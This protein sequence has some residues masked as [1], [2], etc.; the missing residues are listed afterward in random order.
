MPSSTQLC[1]SRLAVLLPASCVIALGALAGACGASAE[2][3]GSLTQ[4]P[5]DTGVPVAPSPQE[6]TNGAGPTPPAP[7]PPPAAPTPAPPTDRPT[8]LS[9]IPADA[10]KG[11]KSDI[12]V[13]VQ[14]D[15]AMDTSSVASAYVSLSLPSNA[16]ALAWNA[17]E[18]ELTVTPNAPLGYSAG[19]PAV[20]AYGYGFTISKSAKDKSGQPL[21]EDFALGFSTLRRVTE[22][23]PMTAPLTGRALSSGTFSSSTL[24]MGDVMISGVEREGRALFTFVVAS[25]PDAAEIEKATLRADVASY[26]GAPEDQL[27]WA[28]VA[29]IFY[30][31]GTEGFAA[32]P[33]S[34]TNA[35]LTS[36]LNGN[37]NRRSA[38]VTAMVKDDLANRVARAD[39]S[40]YRMRYETS[41]NA[42][43]QT[44]MAFF[45]KASGSSLAV[46]Y[47]LE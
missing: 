10:A 45:N 32:E 28:S 12:A 29:H 41:T 37:P 24:A 20:G 43:N 11:V 2:A 27:G 4:D 13:V 23:M 36:G 46:T 47:L 39:R 5:T 21:A 7:T 1:A 22:L 33:R 35:T 26:E 31:V 17:S 3:P 44:D 15:R 30:D 19:G 9:T 16:V 42:N 8:V 38:D 25:L 14:F 34:V 6:P 40:Q 18:D